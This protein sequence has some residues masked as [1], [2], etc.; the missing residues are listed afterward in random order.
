MRTALPWVLPSAG[1][2][3]WGLDF[4]MVFAAESSGAKADPV[5]IGGLAVAFAAMLLVSLVGLVVTIRR[6]D[7]PIG[8]ILSAVAFL[9]AARSV[10][11]GWV[12][13]G[14]AAS[15]RS[16]PASAIVAWL[17][18]WIWIPAIGMLGT[19][20][21]LLFPTGALPSPRWR[22][23]G[24]LAV[25]GITTSVLSAALDPGPLEDYPGLA[26]PLPLPAAFEAVTSV[27][28]FGFAVLV[29]SIILSIVSVAVRA[30]RAGNV[31]REQIKW[32]A[33]AG[34]LFAVG[35]AV[36]LFSGEFDTTAALG[37]FG[38][39]AALA[40]AAGIAIQRY[41]LFDIDRLI[42]RTFSYAIVTAVLGGLFALI[43]LLP[44]VVVGAGTNIPEY[45]I[46][47]ATVVVA[48]L[49]RSV[50]RRV[51]GAVDRRFNRARYDAARTIEE[52]SARLREE[53]DINTLAA[54]LQA[55]VTRT[56]QPAYVSLWIREAR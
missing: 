45:L 26:N 27:L 54:E 32:I 5:G 10:T 46:A 19:F 17:S 31:E 49:F 1:I 16:L 41:R 51:Q 13:Y 18:G 22:G 36:A 35:F 33:F 29:L 48:A 34:S 25:L 37:V 14:P 23:V 47:A 12:L 3:L 24:W 44:A 28:G 55:V 56:M 42:S 8:W 40:L 2:L 50:R 39:I 6:R 38:P 7:H 4:Y 21:F 43:V 53:V 52:F 30:R 15:G 9:V 11:D 20:F